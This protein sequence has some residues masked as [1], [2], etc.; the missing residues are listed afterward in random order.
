MSIGSRYHIAG[1]SRCGVPA[2]YI[3]A[4]LF[5]TVHCIETCDFFCACCPAIDLDVYVDDFAL[6]II[7]LEA[8]VLK[9]MPHAAGVL[10]LLIRSML[11]CTVAL[12]KADDVASSHLLLIKLRN[13]LGEL[14][15]TKRIWDAAV[16]LGVDF[17]PAG[18]RKSR[19]RRPKAKARVKL[20]KH[21]LKRILIVRK[22]IASGRG[23]ISKILSTGVKPALGYGA[24]VNGATDAKLL[25]AR[26]NLLAGSSPTARGT[27]FRAK[28][29]RHGDSCGLM[30]VAQ[31]HMWAA[32]IW[33][34]VANLPGSHPS[35]PELRRA[36]TA[37]A[38]ELASSWR[39]ARGPL[40]GAVLSL[41]R[42]GWDVVDWCTWTDDRG[43]LILLTEHS[44]KFVERAL[45]DGIQ[46]CL[47]RDLAGH[48]CLEQG[49]DGA[50]ALVD[51]TR[52]FLR[53]RC[54]TALQKSIAAVVFCNSLWTRARADEAGYIVDSLI[55]PLCQL[56]NDTLWHRLYQCTAPQVVAIRD[57]D[58]ARR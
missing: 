40:A 58:T 52:S 34:A 21:R 6:S 2:G 29:A 37:A 12:D 48:L 28:L 57:A 24:C 4:L 13:L 26:R 36:W 3:L 39:S 33:R 19:A 5:V 35:L 41:R 10:S 14:G 50:R 18:V 1:F 46:R 54:K 55:C 20:A 27:S 17:N 56:A 25:P 8:K 30:A 53:S 49:V 42:I 43:F 44:P 11:G 16:H 45:K 15:G 7:G 23:R 38:P 32:E 51:I 22:R 47:E 31:A 9:S